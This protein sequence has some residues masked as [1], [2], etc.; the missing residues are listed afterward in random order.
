MKLTKVFLIVILSFYNLFSQSN[1]SH[2]DKSDSLI[3]NPS[4]IGFYNFINE[5]TPSTSSIT[6]CINFNQNLTENV[7][8]LPVTFNG[9]DSVRIEFLT[10]AIDANPGQT[11]ITIKN[12]TLENFK[13]IVFRVRNYSNILFQNCTFKDINELHFLFGKENQLYSPDNSFSTSINIV[14]CRFED[15]AQTSFGNMLLIERDTAVEPD[16]FQSLLKNVTISNCYFKLINPIPIN[17]HNKA[18]IRFLRLDSNFAFKNII[19]SN[20]SIYFI[21]CQDTLSP[22]GIVIEQPSGTEK[23]FRDME[24]ELNKNIY[25]KNNYIFTDSTTINPNHGIFVMGPYKNV[26][27]SRNIID[28]FGFVMKDTNEVGDT[29]LLNDGALHLYGARTGI[30]SDNINLVTINS[31]EILHSRSTGIRFTG[32]F[33]VKISNNYVELASYTPLFAPYSN[34]ADRA[35]IDI[36]TGDYHDTTGTRQTDSISVINN[37]IYCNYQFTSIGILNKF[38]KNFY[39]GA[40]T[41]YYPTTSGICY[42]GANDCTTSEIGNSKIEDNIIDFGGQHYSHLKSNFYLN[43]F[44]HVDY[45]HLKSAISF[46]RL[47]NDLSNTYNNESLTIFNNRLINRIKRNDINLFTFRD[48]TGSH[49]DISTTSEEGNW[50]IIGNYGNLFY[51]G[52]FDGDGNSDIFRYKSSSTRKIEVVLSNSQN[53]FKHLST[54]LIPSSQNGPWEWHIG[55]FNGDGKDDLMGYQ[56]STKNVHVWFSNGDDFQYKN[57]WLIASSQYGPGPWEW[58]IGDFNGDGKDDLMGYQ[59]STKNVHVWFPYRVSN[60]YNFQDKGVWLHNVDNYGHWYIGDFDANGK[61]DF[62][63]HMNQYGGAI[64]SLNNEIITIHKKSDFDEESN[65]GIPIIYKLSQNYPN[66]FNPIT[67]I[68]YSIKE[69]GFVRLKVYNILGEEIATLVN[70]EKKRGNYS[71]KFN[72]NNLSSGVYFYTLRVNNFVQS[73]KMILLK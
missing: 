5:H 48:E 47:E 45:Q 22:Q 31:N 35:G 59:A 11:D 24:Y 25:I 58:H 73:R 6:L 41:I 46:L 32:G 66:P 16:T 64:I 19:I 30:Y 72:G 60:G 10:K 61:D 65:N 12:L 63:R 37:T 71:V 15:S 33:N 29:I 50:T 28:G 27:V 42:W 51:V 67:T 49:I 8:D 26:N 44:N 57:V 13:K 54:W 7:F 3:T 40:N 68:N 9:N 34:T 56:A 36:G 21:G 53:H 2:S 23:N 20:D 52:D 70:E 39:I 69:K 62:M 1:I 18:A 43:N 14:N 4:K 38:T 17:I 55:D